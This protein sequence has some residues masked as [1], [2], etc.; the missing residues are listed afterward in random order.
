VRA[1]FL[2]LALVACSSAFS[3]SAIGLRQQPAEG[4]GFRYVHRDTRVGFVLPAIASEGDREQDDAGF[5]RLVIDTHEGD[6]LY[7]VIL[8]RPIDGTDVEPANAI[9]VLSNGLVQG[10]S[11]RRDDPTMVGSHAA[12][13]ITLGHATGGGNEAAF[14][15]TADSGVLVMME[16]VGPSPV[17]A[18]ADAFFGSLELGCE[19]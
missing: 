3:P 2:G 14:L 7:R 4:G 16:V 1:A 12:R 17:D 11:P 15:I 13:R 9:T 18:Q 10:Q 6:V 8:L 5:E 19:L